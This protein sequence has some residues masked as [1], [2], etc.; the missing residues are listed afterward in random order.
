MKYLLNRTSKIFLACVLLSVGSVAFASS[1]EHPL[2]NVEIPKD[3]ASLKRGAMIYYNTCRMCHSMK[4]VSYQNL[5]EI[6]F[7]DKE[8]N[9]LR[10]D[11][12]K[13][14]KLASTTSDEIN[15]ELFGLVPPDLTLMAKARENGAK[16]IYT[17]LTSYY[18]KS[19]GV[20]DNKFFPNVKMPDIFA[21]SVALDAEE[22]SKIE[23]KVKDVSAFLLWASDPRAEERKSLGVYVIGYLI[24]LSLMLYFV[25][26]RVWS[27]LGDCRT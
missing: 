20:Y 10:G 18:E 1:D 7:S 15:N 21:Y 24:V 16:Y 3:E 12:L 8:I 22:K 14:E 27:R 4:Y 9:G 2:A 17:L 5:A 6:G 26:K 23:N 13:S 11:R 19:E 25:M